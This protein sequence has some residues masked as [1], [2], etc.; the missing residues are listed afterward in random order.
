MWSWRLCAISLSAPILIVG[1]RVVATRVTPDPS[2][3]RRRRSPDRSPL[4]PSPSW[5]PSH[6]TMLHSP[7]FGTRPKLLP[8]P[9]L[10]SSPVTKSTMTSSKTGPNSSLHSYPNRYP[11]LLS[12]LFEQRPSSSTMISILPV[13]LSFD[14]TNILTHA[15]STGGTKTATLRS[16][17]YTPKTST[18]QPVRLPSAPLGMSSLSQNDNGLMTSYIILLARTSGRPPH[19]GK[20]VQSNESPHSSS[21]TPPS[22]T[23]QYS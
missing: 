17:L 4:S 18:D 16:L 19:G 23:T 14:I 10:P 13:H 5:T 6:Q 11:F 20:A 1:S 22:H 21:R 3:T 15:A 12:T 9:P 2:S 8:S 7:F